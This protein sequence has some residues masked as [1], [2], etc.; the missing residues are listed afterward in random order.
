MN[1]VFYVV[2]ASELLMMTADT[3][4]PPMI[5][6]GQVLKQS[7]SFTIASPSRAFCGIKLICRAI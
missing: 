4:T 2:N 1:M 6:T 5:E 3:E 7:G